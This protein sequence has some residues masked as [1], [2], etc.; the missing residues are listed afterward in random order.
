MEN[1]AEYLTGEVVSLSEMLDAREKRV[2]RQEFLLEKYNQTLICFTMNIPGDIKVFPLACLAFKEGNRLIKDQLRRHEYTVIHQEEDLSKTGYT[3]NYSVNAEPA[4]LKTQMAAIE[5]S[6]ALGRLF[7]IDVITKEGKLSR[8]DNRRCLI[9]GNSAFECARSRRH[10][11]TE[12]LTKIIDVISDYFLKVTADTIAA[13]AQ[14]ALLYEVSLTPKP[15]LV[16]MANSGSHKDMDFFSFISSVTVLGSFFRDSVK[17]GYCSKALSPEHLM[18]SLRYPGMLAEDAMLA[19][20]SGANT[21]KGAIFSFGIICAALGYLYEADNSKAIIGSKLFD[22]CKEMSKGLVEN[23]IVNNFADKEEPKMGGA[24]GE[25]ASGF[26]TVRS[27]GI[28]ILK[29]DSN[30]QIGGLAALMNLAMNTDDTNILRRGKIE[31][32]SY[33]KKNASDMI[34]LY[35]ADRTDLFLENLRIMD[36]NFIEKNLSPGGSADLLAISLFLVFLESAKVV[37]M[38]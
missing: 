1:L 23:E 12:L 35:N 30:L 21:H 29:K 5:D 18:K 25:A 26:Q 15:G 6:C 7:D 3:A 9:C 4:E 38:G 36:M 27:Y 28:P 19:E 13:T 2:S 24:R 37:E 17:I 31:A 32:L 16:D 14:K 33:V 34:E 20:T 22:L 8:N 10:G 11:L